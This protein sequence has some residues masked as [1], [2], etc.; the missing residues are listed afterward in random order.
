VK[1]QLFSNY[2][3]IIIGDH[4]AGLWAARLLLEKGLKVLVVPMGTGKARNFAP[5]F[6]VESFDLPASDFANRE[7]DP[8]QVLTPDRRFRVFSSTA[9]L[10]EECDFVYR[11]NLADLNTLDPQLVRGLAYLYRGSETGPVQADDWKTIYLKVNEVLYFQKEEGWLEEQF[12]NQ[13]KKMGGHVLPEDRLDR[14]FVE[15]KAFVGIQVEGSSSMITAERVLV[16]CNWNLVQGLMSETVPLI[17]KPAGWIFE[18]KLKVSDEAIPVGLTSQMI[19][20][21]AG[22]PVI[23]MDQVQKGEFVLRTTLPYEDFTL[24][25]NEQRKICQRLLKVMGRVIPDLEYNLSRVYPD[26]RDPERTEQVDLVEMYPFHSLGQIPSS[27]L[28]YAMPGLGYQTTVQGMGF[29]YDEAF[30][31]SGEWGAYQAAQQVIQDWAKAT[32]R[33]DLQKINAAL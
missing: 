18:M 28:V 5:R 20:V 23:E 26:I 12:L 32:N 11:K 19:W 15:K 30:P 3:F 27:R 31:R 33:L 7:M 16:A 13:I 29:A 14:V 8:I 21:Q 25:R 4:P 24:E 10:T 2:D 9:A 6:V 17:S 22:A 1:Q